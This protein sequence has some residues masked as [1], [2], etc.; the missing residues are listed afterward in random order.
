MFFAFLF[1]MTDNSTTE[2]AEQPDARGV[3]HWA[4]RILPHVAT[5]V[6]AVV[7]SLGLQTML[8]RQAPAVP[9][10]SA[11]P[12]VVVVPSTATAVP[13]PTAGTPQPTA[14]LPAGGIA[15]QEL[16]DLRTED[17]RLWSAIYLSRAINLIADAES[18]LR[19]N[20]LARVDQIIVAT[21]DSLA[22][23]YDRTADALR[24]PIAQLRRDAGMMR[25]DLY[26]RPEGMDTRLARLR[27]TLLALIAERR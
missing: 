9:L 11:T 16:I 15:R 3:R 27:Q 5:A 2:P 22:L 20:D 7:A 4:A 8:P 19:A 14:P 10:P 6:V 13:S 23:A 21:D 24:D 17:D 26:L 18:A 12:S 1:A 25:E